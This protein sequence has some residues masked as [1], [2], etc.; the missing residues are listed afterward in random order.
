M[1]KVYKK[2]YQF[3]FKY[4]WQFIVFIVFLVGLSI[5]ESIHPYFYKLF[6]EE[7]PSGN[8]Q[9]L[10]NILFAYSGIRVLQ[11]ILDILTYFFGD[12]VLLPAAKDARLAV[13]KKIQDLDFAFSLS[14]STGSLISTMKRGDTA[15]FD[16]HHSINIKMVRIIINFLVIMWFFVQIKLEIALVMIISM[17]LNMIFA[18][19]LIRININARKKF[20]DEEDNI[21]NVIVDNLINFETVKLFAKEDEEYKKLKRQFLPWL[22]ELWGYAN[23]FRKIDIIVGTLGEISM[24]LVLF[25][26]LQQVVDLSLSA[27]EYVMILGFVSS[28]YPRFF[29]LIFELRN[30]GKHNVDIKKYFDVFN[31]DTIVKDIENPVKK[32]YAKGEIVFDNVNFSYPE[33]RDDALKNINLRIREGQSIAFVGYSGAGKTTITKLLMRFYDP[34]SGKITIDGV[35]IAHLTK[36]NLRS[37]MGVV[38]QEPILFNDSIAYNIGYGAGT[39]NLHEIIAASK[40]ANLHD[41]ISELSDGYD[42]M[43][44][45]RGVRLSGGQKQRLA[46][47]RMILS[48]PDIIIFDEAT[49]QLDSES[50]KLIQDA[51]WKAS[52][53][54]TTIIIAHRLSSITKADKIIVMDDGE[55]VEVG[56]HKQLLKMSGQYNNFWKLQTEV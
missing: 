49:S 33:G 4:G 12:S 13:F 55:I 15:F 39:T 28:F 9:M 23:S 35:N 27:G 56:T 53:N 43:V 48:N 25:V 37:F 34:D 26:G 46:I 21:S 2:Y 24:F 50:E 41:F 20:N 6:I 19:F 14:R 45:E 8:F 31:F 11:L 54:K 3:L 18:Y 36:T 10:F 22:T 5:I 1:F 17:I 30:I 40:M 51:F 44:G 52:K 32:E 7:L 16:L 42:T 47:A 29:E 38:P